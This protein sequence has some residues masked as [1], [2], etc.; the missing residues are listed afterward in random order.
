MIDQKMIDQLGLSRPARSFGKV[1]MFG[2]HIDQRRFPHIAPSDKGVF[3][4]ILIGTFSDIAVADDKFGGGDFQ[5][6]WFKSCLSAGGFE[7]SGSKL[8]PNNY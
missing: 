6:F 4:N 5:G 1:L 2:Q 3:G 7:V 8:F